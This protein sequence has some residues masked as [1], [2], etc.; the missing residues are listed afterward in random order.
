MLLHPIVTVKKPETR[1]RKIAM[2]VV[3][4]AAPKPESN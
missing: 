3:A 1:A 2:L 4:L